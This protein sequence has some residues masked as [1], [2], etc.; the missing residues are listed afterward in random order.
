MVS[1]DDVEGYADKILLLLSDDDLRKRLGANGRRFAES[2][3]D[4]KKILLQLEA[5]YN[6]LLN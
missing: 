1:A 4:K 5:V 6:E 2:R 3:L